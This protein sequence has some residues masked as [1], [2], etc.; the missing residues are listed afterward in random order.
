[1]DVLDLEPINEK[2]VFLFLLV[3]EKTGIFNTEAINL[4]DLFRENK[5]DLI[6]SDLDTENKFNMKITKY[7]DN[8]EMHVFKVGIPENANGYLK[9]ELDRKKC[10][11]KELADVY[12]ILEDKKSFKAQNIKVWIDLLKDDIEKEEYE[13]DFKI[14]PQWIMKKFLDFIRKTDQAVIKLLH[15]TSEGLFDELKNLGKEMN[16]TVYAF[17]I[18]EPEISKKWVLYPK[19]MK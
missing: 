7:L 12:E 6:T 15:F 2:K 18:M 5:F 8:F 3:K 17:E 10:L 11:M 13:L 1:M 14:R 19:C 4:L 9:E 16:M